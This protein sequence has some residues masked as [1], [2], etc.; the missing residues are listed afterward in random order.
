MTNERAWTLPSSLRVVH[1]GAGRVDIAFREPT[2][3]GPRRD[4]ESFLLGQS[5]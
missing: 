2:N 5:R 1:Y 4:P 3:G